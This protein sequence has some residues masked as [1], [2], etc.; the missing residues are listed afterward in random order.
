MSEEKENIWS[1][2][3]VGVFFL[4]IGSTIVISVSVVVTVLQ[5]VWEVLGPWLKH[6]NWGHYTTLG[7]Y[8]K[9]E[10]S[11]WYIIRRLM[12][13]PSCVCTRGPCWDIVADLVCC[14][15][16]VPLARLKLGRNK[17]DI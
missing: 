4:I 12:M 1:Y 10:H 14:Y 16:V 17:S 15:K 13:L 8:L 7:E 3:G 9:E 2:F 6:G 11:E 5:N